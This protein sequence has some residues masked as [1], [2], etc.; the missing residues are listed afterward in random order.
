M[1]RID[2]IA[3]AVIARIG[4]VDL[5]RPRVDKDMVAI[6]LTTHLEELALQHRPTRWFHSAAAGY[7]YVFHLARNAAWTAAD[8]A[9][10]GAVS[11]SVK[12]CLNSTDYAAWID[13]WD[14]A[15]SAAKGAGDG[16]VWKTAWRAQQR[17]AWVEARSAAEHS[18][19]IA[20]RSTIENAVRAAACLNG[21][22]RVNHPVV[23]KLANMWLP[24]VDAFEAGLW[25]YWITSR[26]LICVPHPT[27]SSVGSR[28][29]GGEAFAVEWPEVRSPEPTPSAVAIVPQHPR[30]C[31]DVGL[32]DGFFQR[33]LSS[34]LTH[35]FLTCGEHLSRRSIV[36]CSCS[37][38][39]GQGSRC[40]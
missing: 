14:T 36:G 6:A 26:E 23:T 28:S 8:A 5:S 1:T 13:A 24:M 2:P 25:L 18:A 10:A 29:H 20:A 27:I 37:A 12:H 19:W 17:A 9:Q 38:G 39:E 40:R 16:D 32:K 7:R 4:R 15:W 31:S 35:I 34:R 3:Q 22:A 33:S 21:S 30:G 11:A